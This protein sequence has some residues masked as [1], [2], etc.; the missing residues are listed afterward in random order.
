MALPLTVPAR[1]A[2][3]PAEACLLAQDKAPASFLGPGTSKHH[4][5][6]RAEPNAHPLPLFSL[7]QA[8]PSGHL[9][10]FLHVQWHVEP[11]GATWGDMRHPGSAL[12][13]PL[14][15]T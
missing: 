8:S 6:T 5:N 9:D 4:R 3:K 14:V 7:P 2:R 15:V 11:H 12:P 10:S 1:V 13:V